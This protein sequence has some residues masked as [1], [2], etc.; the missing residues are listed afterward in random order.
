MNKYIVVKVISFSPVLY[1]GVR[2]APGSY[3]SIKDSDFDESAFKKVDAN[4]IEVLNA[5]KTDLLGRVA[6]IDIILKAIANSQKETNQTS[7]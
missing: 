6:D 7:K 3:I 5:E 1:E 4:D 2:R